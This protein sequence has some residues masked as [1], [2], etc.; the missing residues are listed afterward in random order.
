[1]FID[2]LEENT[3]DQGNSQLWY[4][5][6]RKRLTASTFGKICK[7]RKSTSCKNTVHKLFYGQN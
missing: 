5:E 7:I 1:M 4:V 6:K 3:R 2:K